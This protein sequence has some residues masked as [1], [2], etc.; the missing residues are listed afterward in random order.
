MKGGTVR[1]SLAITGLAVLI[2][3]RVLQA[4]GDFI[5]AKTHGTTVAISK[6]ANGNPSFGNF[7]KWG[8]GF[9][10]LSIVMVASSDSD[11]LREP[12]GALG[13]LIAG[14]AVVA[15]W[16]DI[17]TMFG[18]GGGW[19]SISYS[20]AGQPVNYSGIPHSEVGQQGSPPVGQDPG[21]GRVYQ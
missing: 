8:A 10:G 21:R 11:N 20:G 9:L 16:P 18:I 6:D 1:T 5:T 14:T 4:M 19:S 3:L 12:M 17:Q 13:V 2:H 15:A 7:V